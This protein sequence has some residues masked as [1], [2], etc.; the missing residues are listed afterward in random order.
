MV[1]DLEVPAAL[2]GLEVEGDEAVREEVV[3]QPV[4]AVVVVGRHLD[5]QV[6]H[7]QLGVDRHLGPHAGVAGVAPRVAFPGVV[8]ELVAERDGVEDPLPLAG[9][10]VVA[11]DEALDVAHRSRR[12]AGQVRRS[13]DDGVVDRDRGRVQADLAGDQ[14]DVLVEVLLQV[15]DAVVAEVG[16]PLAGERVQADQVVAGGDVEDLS[17]AAVIQPGQPA[18]R[19]PPRRRR[20]PLAFVVAVEPED[21]AGGRVE[22]HRR[23]P[24][25]GRRV[26]D[27]V[28]HQRRRLQAEF[29]TRSEVVGAEGPGD[30]QVVEVVAVDLV[31]GRVSRMGEVAAVARPL[32]VPG[33]LLL[34][35]EAGGRRDEADHEGH[36]PAISE[37]DVSHSESSVLPQ[38]ASI[39]CPRRCRPDG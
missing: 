19:Q 29:R 31:E 26:Q 22:G 25:P 3:A 17:V 39:Q 23:P 24:R 7:V 16:Q 11:A 30:L 15:D 6:D 28:D 36:D 33:A 21:L 18:P 1:G 27:A 35:R 4:P 13:D 32:A 8:A 9:V 12:A 5:R 38:H 10:D 14:V 34:R 20:A 37:A 2:A